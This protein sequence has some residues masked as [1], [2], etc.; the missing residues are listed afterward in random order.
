V[1]PSREGQRYSYDSGSRLD[2][3]TDDV[4][5]LPSSVPPINGKEDVDEMYRA[6][7]RRYREIKHETVIE[8]VRGAGDW[9]FLWGTD[10]L[11]LTPESGETEIHMQGKGL[12]I[13][14]RHSDG[15][16]RFWRGIN[17]MTQ[18]PLSE[19][20]WYS[21]TVIFQTGRY[22]YAR[23][24]SETRTVRRASAAIERA[25]DRER[26]REQTDECRASHTRA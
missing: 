26:R 7:F 19:Y 16:W 23:V 3:A 17:N 24:G 20:R 11:H 6:F 4:V 14:K 13:L 1:A 21:A 18:R 22:S 15:S 8:E 10:E 5:F 9:A 25:A 12:S 2:P